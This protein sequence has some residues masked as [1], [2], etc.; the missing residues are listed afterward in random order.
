M[1]FEN[2]V[3]PTSSYRGW[4]ENENLYKSDNGDLVKSRLKNDNLS[5]ILRN[6]YVPNDHNETYF[7]HLN[8]IIQVIKV[9]NPSY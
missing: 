7:D 6:V 5:L 1:S 3:F 9:G 4:T 8:D 2:V